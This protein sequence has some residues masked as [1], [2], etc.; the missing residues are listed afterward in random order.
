MRVERPFL[1]IVSAS[2]GRAQLGLLTVAHRRPDGGSR[3]TLRHASATGLKAAEVELAR[4][5]A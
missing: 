5:V 3:V 2:A 1:I 4:K